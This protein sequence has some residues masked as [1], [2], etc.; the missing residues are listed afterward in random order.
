MSLLHSLSGLFV[1]TACSVSAVH[2][3]TQDPPRF[4]Q[5]RHEAT[6][7]LLSSV[8]GTDSANGYATLPPG[9]RLPYLRTF[10]Q[11]RNPLVWTFYYGHFAGE[12]R[13]SVTESFFEFGDLIPAKYHCNAEPV[14]EAW[15]SEAVSLLGHFAEEYRAD[16][17]AQSASG[18][19]L[20][21]ARRFESAQRMFIRALELYDR[22]P[23]ARN[24][25]GLAFLG[26]H[27]RKNEA[28]NAFREAV[29]ADPD[30]TAAWYAL[31]ICHVSMDAIDVDHRFR[32]VIGRFP[33]HHDAH[34]KLGVAYE[35]LHNLKKAA[36]AYTQQIVHNNGH[37]LAKDRLARV[38]L[39]MSWT[40][41][42]APLT[43]EELQ[44][45]SERDRL[46]YL[47]ILAESYLGKGDARAS[48]D[49]YVR[50]LRLLPDEEA[51]YYHDVAL[52]ATAEEIR[53]LE[54]L[55]GREREHYLVAFWLR[56]DSTPTSPVNE[57]QL[58]HYRRVHYAR[59]NYGEGRQPWDRRGEV[60]ITLGHPDHRSWSTNLVFETDPGVVRVKNRLNEM[61]ARARD[62]ISTG[63]LNILD[64]LFMSDV[65]EIRG[66]PMFP[67]PRPGDVLSGK[68]SLNAEWELWIYADVSGGIEITFIDLQGDGIYEFAEVPGH[69]SYVHLWQHLSPRAVFHRA[70][71]ANPSHY[72][73][74]YGGPPLDL[75]VSHAQFRSGRDTALEVYVGVPWSA[76]P[77]SRSKRGF[78]A[79]LERHVVVYDVRG[80]IV[81]D[82]SVHADWPVPEQGEEAGPTLVDQ[83]RKKLKPG[84]YYLGVTA[85][86]PV[87][88]AVQVYHQPIDVR[89]FGRNDLDMSD[90]EVA[91]FIDRTG[92]KR[93][94]PFRKGEVRVLPLPTSTVT[95]ARPVYLY[96]EVYNLLDTGD[97]TRYRV[98]Y[99][100]EGA[101][102]TGVRRLLGGVARLLGLTPREGSIQVSYEHEGDVASEPVY[103]ALDLESIEGDAFD[104]EVGVTDLRRTDEPTV[105][106]RIR[107]YREE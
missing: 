13:Y 22:F 40:N 77:L 85:R 98:D 45:L 59:Q 18:Y 7:A 38:N 24:G 71:S 25:V 87:T 60:Y 56:K 61:T 48:H 4:D 19:A 74:D 41:D 95:T 78:Q 82:D 64:G 91:S 53:A 9:E 101:R 94:S 80:R 67:V 15:V 76:L 20:V 107:I 99:R 84:T 104:I 27:Q 90:V 21:H 2:G 57:R 47:P 97:R 35:Y 46:R 42:R 54:G 81:F 28:L 96:Y 1:A 23:E 8:A 100:V 36:G 79:T 6:V 10:W 52:I 89:T 44:R 83:V 63:D 49:A 88:R 34:Y 86:D 33:E 5:D 30:Y 14:P 68:P 75:S 3:D 65:S 16:P 93:T 70:V 37:E 106:Q 50:Y 39:E 55:T 62:E 102:P 72:E 92:G 12:R 32:Q 43:I 58:E 103:V 26:Q 73:Y 51:A 105:A 29:A 11:A 69:S 66:T 17:I 31:A